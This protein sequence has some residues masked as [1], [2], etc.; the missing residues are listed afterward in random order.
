MMSHANICTM[1]RSTKKFLGNKIVNSVTLLAF[2]CCF[3]WTFCTAQR[4]VNMYIICELNVK[5]RSNLSWYLRSQMIVRFEFA[6]FID[7]PA[8]II[9][10]T[11]SLTQCNFFPLLCFGAIFAINIALCDDHRDATNILVVFFKRLET[12]RKIWICL[13]IIC[14][15][16]CEV[17]HSL[18]GS[19]WN[20][21]S[22]C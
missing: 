19:L 11:K 4:S 10:I 5:H 8:Q 18:A 16:L 3:V 9:F 6:E 15:A 7:C 1:G 20:A 14:V 12:A 17:Q 21:D 13:Y 2:C 22:K